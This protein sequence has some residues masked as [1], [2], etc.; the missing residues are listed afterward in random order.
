MMLCF[1]GR[2]LSKFGLA[3]TDIDAYIHDAGQ[4]TSHF[5][6]LKELWIDSRRFIVYETAHMFFAGTL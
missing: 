1:D 5:N 3:P 6:V 2:F 4:P